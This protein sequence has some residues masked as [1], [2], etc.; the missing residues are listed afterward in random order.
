MTL[1]DRRSL[2]SGAPFRSRK[3]N[4]IALLGAGGR[5]SGLQHFGAAYNSDFSLVDLDLGA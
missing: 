1:A 5:D 3:L 2:L 4:D